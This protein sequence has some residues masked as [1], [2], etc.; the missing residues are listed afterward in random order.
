MRTATRASS[1]W[2][3]APWRRRTSR[4]RTTSTTC[5]ATPITASPPSSAPAPTWATWRSSCA[6]RSIP[7]AARILTVGRGL[8][9]PGSGPADASRNDVPFA[10]TSPAEARKAVQELA[11]LKPDFVKIWVDDR[12][13]RA[14]KLTPEMFTAAADEAHKLG[15]RS[16]AHV[17]DLADAKLL[18][19]RRRRRLHAQRPRPGGRRRIHQARQG[20][21][22]LDHAQPRRHQPRDAHPRERHAGLARRAA[23]AR[24]DPAGA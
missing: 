19:P 12:N 23:G 2:S 17:F 10:V 7:N 13:G 24:D 18:D 1:T 14:K 20:A 8:A 5:S 3:P 22:H 15:L 9:Y 21:R 6:T 4:A 16:I 11:P